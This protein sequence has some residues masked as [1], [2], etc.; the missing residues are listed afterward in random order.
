MTAGDVGGAGCGDDCICC[1]CRCCCC[2]CSCCS[3]PMAGGEV[4]VPSPSSGTGTDASG[5]VRLRGGEDRASPAWDCTAMGCDA[6]DR[7]RRASSASSAAEPLSTLPLLLVPGSRAAWTVVP[8]N[9]ATALFASSSS[10]ST[11]AGLAGGTGVPL[12]GC[13]AALAAAARGEDEAAAAAA[14]PSEPTATA[15]TLPTARSL[16]PSV[17]LAVSMWTM[18]ALRVARGDGCIVVVAWLSMGSGGGGRAERNGAACGIAS[19]AVAVGVGWRGAMRKG[20]DG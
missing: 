9:C 10:P 7:R 2:C 4:I 17:V 11:V 3:R 12:D 19:T 5:G 20:V 6:L 14:A 8:F 13:T 18:T 1:A 16:T 15:T